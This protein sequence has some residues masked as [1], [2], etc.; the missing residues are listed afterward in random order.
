[1]LTVDAKRLGFSVTVIDPTPGS[2]A[3]QVGAEQIVAPLTEETETRQLASLSDF[4]TVEIEHTN[5]PI[6]RE[7]RETG[8]RVNPSPE[9]LDILRDKL[10][11]KQFFKVQEYPPLNLFQ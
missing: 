5:T 10:A 4:L 6:L 3:A 2:P 11:Q 9:T 7:L 8:V 1:M